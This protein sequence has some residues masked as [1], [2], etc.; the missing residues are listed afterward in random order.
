MTDA[1][2]MRDVLRR[3]GA[4]LV[5][6]ALDALGHG[7]RAFAAT[8]R[9]VTTTAAFAGPA[10][11]LQYER[12]PPGERVPPDPARTV[13]LLEKIEATVQ[14]GDVMVLAFRDS[15]PPWGALGGLYAAQYRNLGAAG[16]V[17]DA[18]VRDRDELESIG[19]PVH[20]GGLSP[21]NARGRIRFVAMDVPVTVAGQSVAPGDWLVGDGDGAVVVPAAAA[22]AAAF[23]QWLD[24]ALQR[25]KDAAVELAGGARLS[26]VFRKLGRI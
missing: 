17:T 16:V 20:A 5:S 1:A 7:E 12:V 24:E 9:P 19:L 8:I 15:A 14:S 23:P 13:A 6:D 21:T 18:F 11:I 4:A 25:E 26:A 3:A 22:S 10:R 2:A